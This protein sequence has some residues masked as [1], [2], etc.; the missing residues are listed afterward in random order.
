MTAAPAPIPLDEVR[1]A[2]AA[3][4]GG[5]ARVSHT[6]AFWTLYV[7]TLRQHVH[8]KRWLV[9]MAL[10]LLPAGLA[11]LLRATAVDVPSIALEFILAFMFIPQALLPIVALLYASGMI[12]DEQEDQT[13]TYLLVR[14]IPK[15]ALYSVKLLAT[16]TTTV[17]LTV[18]V[19]VLT[20]AAIYVGA[21]VEG[22][23]VPLRCL[24]AAS[25]HSLAVVAYCS[26][27]GLL[28]LLTKRILVVGILYTA[29]VEG[30]L[31][32]LP[33]GIRLATVIYY[34]RVIAYRTLEFAVHW[35]HG[36]PEDIAGV[37]WQLYPQSDPGLREHPQLSTCIAVLLASSL[38]STILAAW[39]CTGREFH[40]KTPEKD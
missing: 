13:I 12:Q 15:W 34:A 10:F 27:F 24:K 29:I 26:L 35:P 11:I 1:S 6:S 37:A 31:A 38:V 20:Y 8:G 23:N 25:I 40:V 3:A 39:L 5:A 2:N 22:V 4:R 7:L 19:T 32:N 21:G 33:F 16:L 9:M 28:S 30:L 36:G 18:I 17:V 14:P